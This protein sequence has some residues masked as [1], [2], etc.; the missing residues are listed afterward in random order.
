MGGLAGGA[1]RPQPQQSVFLRRRSA[2]HT[3][4]PAGPQT[5]SRH[6]ESLGAGLGTCV[7]T[8]WPSLPQ[9]LWACWSS[10][11]STTRPPARCTVAS[12][13]PRWGPPAPHWVAVLPSLSSSTPILSSGLSTPQGPSLAKRGC[14]QPPPIRR[15]LGPQAHGFQW[16]GRPLCQAAPAAG[17]LQGNSCLPSSLAS[18]FSPSFFLEPSTPS[19][20]SLYLLQIPSQ[21]LLYSSRFP[22]HSSIPSLFSSV[23][24]SL[25]SIP[26]F[27]GVA[28]HLVM[29][30]A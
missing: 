8:A 25:F 18:Q 12:S 29:L 3:A 5:L 10:T 2:T 6:T 1:L 4:Q 9:P 30:R 26:L 11:F 17:S 21:V 19:S 20:V 28:A 15:S 16:P 27:S 24:S 22:P 13:E 14:L 23:F 7:G